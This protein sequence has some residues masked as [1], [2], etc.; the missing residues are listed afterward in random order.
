MAA[1]LN[2]ISGLDKS[3]KAAKDEVAA[4]WV[5]ADK[6]VKIK[7]DKT[8]AELELNNLAKT[9][10]ELQQNWKTAIDQVTW[11]HSNIHW[12]QSRFPDA[13]YTNVIGLCKLADKTEYA[14]EQDYSL[15]AGRYVGV[16]I[17]GDTC[18][19]IDFKVKMKSKF[20]E[21]EKLTESATGLEAQI[22]ENI[23]SL[24]T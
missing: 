18:N 7:A 11:W 23:K 22:S 15:N 13:T 5:E 21:F 12:L 24:L 9:L 17:E 10:D 1:F 19:E 2:E 16:E 8:W 20:C 14:D 6:Q 3:L 4:H